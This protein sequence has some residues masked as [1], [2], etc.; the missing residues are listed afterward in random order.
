MKQPDHLQRPP[1]E[2]SSDDAPPQPVGTWQ[3]LREVGTDVFLHLLM[4][5]ILALWLL[6][7]VYDALWHPLAVPGGFTRG[8]AFRLLLAALQLPIT[9]IL[10][11][12]FAVVGMLID[13]GPAGHA[14]AITG[15]AA[16]GASAPSGC[17][18]SHRGGDAP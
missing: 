17:C 7:L 4:G 1:G 9:W 18:H 10:T 3:T 13:T 15:P 11:V 12:L 14:S 5:L 2:G 6:W 16:H 8:D